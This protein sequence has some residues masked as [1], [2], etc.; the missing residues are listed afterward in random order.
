VILA[1]VVIAIYLPTLRG[2]VLDWD[3]SEYVGINYHVH[4]LSW[5]TV[6]WAFTSTQYSG[7]WHPL[8][9]LSHALDVKI[10]GV[11]PGGH[12][13]TNVWGHHLTNV[14][15]HAANAVLVLLVFRRLSGRFW[16]SVV[17]AAIFALHPL[18]VECV[19]W[20]AERKEL[21]CTFFTLL[22]ILAYLRYTTKT[23]VWRYSLVFVALAAALM[24]KPMAVTLPLVLLLLDYWPLGRLSW[25]AVAE[26]LPLLA[27]SAGCCYM[28]MVAHERFVAE[29]VTLGERA[30]NVVVSY[31][32]YLGK[33][34]WPAPGTLLPLYI[35]PAEV[36]GGLSA[37]RIGL[38]LAVLVVISAAAVSQWRRRPWL[39]VGWLW[40]LGATV[41][42]S[43][44][45]Q[46]GAQGMA[47]RYT[48]ATMWGLVLAIVLLAAEAADR[49]AG[50]RYA[51]V[52]AGIMVVAALSW[53]TWQQE[54]VWAD[55][56][57]LW[58]YTVAHEPESKMASGYLWNAEGLRLVDEGK[59][60]EATKKFR[61][62]L[63]LEPENRLA[64]SNLGILL[65]MAGKYHESLAPLREAVK[66]DPFNARV[67]TNLGVS[68][69]FEPGGIE[70]AVEQFKAALEIDPA[71]IQA[72]GGMARAEML[73]GRPAEA[74]RSWQK[75]AAV[76]PLAPFMRMEMG[77]AL[78][79]A[80][81]L[82]EAAT[83]LR[84]ALALEPNLAPAK[85]ELEQIVAE[86]QAGR[87]H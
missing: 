28:A 82:E 23:T 36:P 15:L 29:A 70:E 60:V 10:Y 44:L 76:A 57:T 64:L 81:R 11:P 45:V 63:A 58:Q 84:A 43:G 3:D 49:V 87:Q 55:S 12:D 65:G 20:I 73:L 2:R 31:A 16:V 34:F 52:A 30:G 51:A 71:R 9:W 61:D 78:H 46:V 80:G 48:Y 69:L 17:A 25:R 24:S 72:L 50:L 59:T 26:K 53:L 47:D 32:A 86:Q 21:L 27:L 33:L 13:L 1:A 7:N 75:A 22:A 40:F 18:R 41:P 37:L 77:V 14:L 19:A 68:L 8:T 83:E 62:V 66:L 67:R 35:H 42:V 38:A 74:V 5:G 54:P 39:L 79:Q 6:E 56:L 4:E 85:A